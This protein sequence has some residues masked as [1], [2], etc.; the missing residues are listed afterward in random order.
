MNSSDPRAPR[1]YAERADRRA[2]ADS[3]REPRLAT[4][5]Y[6]PVF[7]NWIQSP[8]FLKSNVFQPSSL[9][10]GLTVGSAGMGTITRSQGKLRPLANDSRAAPPAGGNRRMLRAAEFAT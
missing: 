10:S 6:F 3:E 9:H 7:T 4:D 5:D 8:W 1:L 2:A